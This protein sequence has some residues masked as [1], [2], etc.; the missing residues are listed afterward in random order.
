MVSMKHIYHY[1]LHR[2]YSDRHFIVYNYL[3]DYERKMSSEKRKDAVIIM[4]EYDFANIPLQLKV[5]SAGEESSVIA[6][7]YNAGMYSEQ[8][9]KELL[10]EAAQ[11]V[12]KYILH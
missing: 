8:D 7:S 5:L 4:P 9:M 12:E 3:A 6:V 2:E 11:A 10:S 1:D